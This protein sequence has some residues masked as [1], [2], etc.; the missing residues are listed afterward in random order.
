[1]AEWLPPRARAHPPEGALPRAPG[2]MPHRRPHLP[3]PSRPAA[4]IVVIALLTILVTL[5]LMFIVTLLA[6]PSH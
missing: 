1:M 4:R 2:A 3:D 6:L 5:V